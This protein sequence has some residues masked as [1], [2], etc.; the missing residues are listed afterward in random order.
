MNLNGLKYLFILKT[1]KNRIPDEILL[2]HHSAAEVCK[3]Q[4]PAGTI[5]IA[6]TKCWH[7][8]SVPVNRHRIMAQYLFS[9]TFWSQQ[10]TPI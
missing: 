7:K 1:G 9:P 2:K 8:A 3:I 10:L 5:I 4:K 6:D